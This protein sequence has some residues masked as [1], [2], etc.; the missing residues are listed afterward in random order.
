M[1]YSEM[2]HSAGWAFLLLAFKGK[3]DVKLETVCLYCCIEF[4]TEVLLPHCDKYTPLHVEFLHSK[5]Y[6][7]KCLS[8]LSATFI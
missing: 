7:C 6:L 3:F 4:L 8:V 2:G 1:N 5:P